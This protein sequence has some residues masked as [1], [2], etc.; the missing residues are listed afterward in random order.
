M[1]AVDSQAAFSEL[2]I[3]CGACGV[4]LHVE[5]HVRTTQCPF[6]ASPSVIERPPSA[7]RPDPT[8]VIGFVVDQERATALVQRWIRSRGLFARSDFKN[9]AASAG[10]VSKTCTR[11][12]SGR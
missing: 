3:S 4:T 1:T 8:F 10:Y 12:L 7:S 9:A 6:C 5:S 2:E 11:S